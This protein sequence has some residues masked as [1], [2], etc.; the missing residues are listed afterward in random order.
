MPFQKVNSRKVKS[1]VEKDKLHG[2]L[3]TIVVVEK[4]D[5][6]VVVNRDIGGHWKGFKFS[7]LGEDHEGRKLLFWIM[8][9]EGFDAR[10][11][12]VAEDSLDVDQL[13]LNDEGIVFS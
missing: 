3:F 5:V 2:P 6:D 12:K 7:Q 8:N 9:N 1:K 10:I 13:S 11:R 4:T